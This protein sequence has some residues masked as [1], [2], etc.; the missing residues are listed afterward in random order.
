MLNPRSRIIRKN[1]AIAAA[2]SGNAGRRSQIRVKI[3]RDDEAMR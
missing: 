2:N 3:L 1:G